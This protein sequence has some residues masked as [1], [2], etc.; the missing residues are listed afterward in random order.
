MTVAVLSTVCQLA[1]AE[2]ES[3]ITDRPDFVESGAVVG[4]GRLQIETSVAGLRNNADGVKERGRATPTLFRYGVSDHWELRLETE[5]FLRARVTDTTRGR[6][7]SESGFA[8]VS[9]GAKWHMQDGDE[10]GKPAIAWLFHADLDSGSS[11]FRGKGVRPSVRM[12]AEW[13]LPD[14]YSLGVMPG[15]IVDKNDDN[16]RF[17]AGIAAVTV[18]KGWT[19][20][21]RTFIEVA[22]EQI[23]SRKNGG[24]QVNYTAGMAYLITK[25]MQVDFAVSHG[26]NHDTPDWQWTAGF[27]IKF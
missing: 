13:E 11:A 22:G 16:K 15:F 3:I 24:S 5:G 18:G 27:S 19:D 23:A 7:V 25:A 1:V 10:H 12:V 6:T 26:A 20:N 9:V 17:V 14:E 2:E 4:K 8:D 21:F